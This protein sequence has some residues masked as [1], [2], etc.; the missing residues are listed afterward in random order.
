MRQGDGSDLPGV[1]SPRSADIG[2]IYV[3]PN[4]DRQSVLAAILT[5]DKLGRKQVVVELPEQNKAFQRSVDFD[6]LKGLRGSMKAQIVF[7]A[8]PGSGPAEFARQR[9]FPVYSSL[10]SYARSLQNRDQSAGAARKSWLPWQKPA[11]ADSTLSTTSPPATSARQAP[12]PKDNEVDQ[13]HVPDAVNGGIAGAATVLGA[14]A[15]AAHEHSPSAPIDFDEGDTLPPDAPEPA[16]A[17]QAPAG[18]LS[19]DTPTVANTGPQPSIAAPGAQSAPR[20]KIIQLPP[21]RSG[22]TG[23]LPLPAIAPVPTAQPQVPT[24]SPPTRQRNTGNMAAVGAAGVAAG[25]TPA[26]GR[27]MRAGGIPP[28]RGS[29]AGPGGGPGGPRRRIGRRWLIALVL[30]LLTLLIACG[31][32]AYASPSTFSHLGL[33]TILPG[34]APPA[35]I[36]IT[37]A[38][39]DVRNTYTIFGVTQNPDATQRQVQA[40]LLSF[41]T[42]AQS[43]TANATGVR[44]TP[45]VQAAGI[46]TFYNGVALDQQVNAGTTFLVAGGVRVVTDSPVDIPPASAPN[47]GVATVSAHAVTPGV[48]GNIVPL[49]INHT[50]CSNIGSITAKNLTPFTGGQDP[51][52]YTFVQQSDID[53]VAKPLEASLVPAARQAL[54]AQVHGNER[55][56]SPPQCGP[57]LSSDHA[58]GDRASSMTVTVSATCTGEVYDL[59]AVQTI[60]ANLLRQEAARDPGA[61]YALTGNL[62]TGITQITLTNASKGTLEMFVQAEGIWVFQFS[63]AQKQA[64]AK[65]VAGKSKSAAQALLLQQMGVARVA[66]QVSGNGDTLPTDPSQISIVVL[67]VPGVTTTIPTGPTISTTPT[68]GPGSPTV[69]TAT[70]TPGVGKG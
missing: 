50:C 29:A 60:A 16:P 4:D 24:T 45:G 27:V 14:S 54:Q 40:R 12:P 55:L 53:G 25:A 35:T 1:S 52:N 32:I 39:K 10:E 31:I 67:S 62:V 43:K 3:A 46:I 22:T 70:P 33:N 48:S 44:Q 11:A 8:P 18:F 28:T 9:R 68:T 63:E 49:A 13:R 66:L 37:P 5:Q 57:N 17:A 23:S 59:Q 21:S 36:T 15:L 19:D 51:Q 30:G 6:G 64:L 65:L 42:P 7:V 47:F 58:A 34:L 41:T 20:P 2:I 61:G 69:P 38:S 56:I 26:A